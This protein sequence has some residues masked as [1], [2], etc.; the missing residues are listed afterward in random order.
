MARCRM[1]EHNTSM[2]KYSD[3]E[4]CID[5]V[6]RLADELSFTYDM[7]TFVERMISLNTLL[8]AFKQTPSTIWGVPDEKLH[9]ED[10]TYFI[11]TYFDTK[12]INEALWVDRIVRLLGRYILLYDRFFEIDNDRYALLAKN[13]R[14]SINEFLMQGGN[15]N[16]LHYSLDY[17][18]KQFWTFWEFEQLI[19]FRILGGHTFSNREIRNFNLCKS[20]DSSLVYARVLDAK[21]PSFNENVSL[22]LHYNQALLDLQDDWEDIEEDVREDMPNV[23]V[24]AALGD[25]SYDRIKRSDHKSIRSVVLGGSDS[26]TTSSIIRLVN[27]YQELTRKISIPENL[28]FLKSLSDHYAETI[29]SSWVYGTFQKIS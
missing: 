1:I 4:D 9:M 16:H 15:S 18:L 21:L 12:D 2:P 25:V 27:E 17:S 5:K 20:S 22:V 29:R 7:A 26:S 24:M 23:F 6:S 10:P 13:V 3:S 8:S 14:A 19:K 11:A 28:V